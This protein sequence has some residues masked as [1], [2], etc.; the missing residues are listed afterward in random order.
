LERALAKDPVQRFQTGSEM[1]GELQRFREAHESPQPRLSDVMRLI[2]R[3]PLVTQKLAVI[4]PPSDSPAADPFDDSD[5]LHGVVARVLQARAAKQART[6][7]AIE[8]PSIMT[9]ATMARAGSAAPKAVALATAVA[10]AL[11]GIAI[12]SQ[13]QHSKPTQPVMASSPPPKPAQ[14]VSEIIAEVLNKPDQSAEKRKLGPAPAAG[15]A[16]HSRPKG[17]AQDPRT[18]AST[19]AGRPQRDSSDR[20][21]SS[22]TSSAIAGSVMSLA[23]LHVVI[24]HAFEE[25]QAFV[26][27]DNRPVYTEELWGAKKR[28]VLLFRHLQGRQSKG[29]T[30][31]PGKHTILVRV[32]SAGSNYDMASSLTQ[33]FSPGSNRTLLVKC[34][35]H[36]EKLELSVQ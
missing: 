29:I 28:R 6:A 18:V 14:S 30:L 17:P 15:S 26:S 21:D 25:G 19:G 31:P 5:S 11:V 27:V 8:Q 7:A 12:W 3:P 10:M 35:E 22:P 23:N 34:D 33:G 4:A 32:R 2:E 9:L 20:A 13:R 1:A 24:E 36:K 16:P